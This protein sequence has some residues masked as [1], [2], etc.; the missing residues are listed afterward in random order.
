M[1]VDTCEYEDY[2]FSKVCRYLYYP[3]KGYCAFESCI[4]M[5]GICNTTK[6]ISYSSTCDGHT[7]KFINHNFVKSFYNDINKA[8]KYLN[9][10]VKSKIL[11]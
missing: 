7:R 1:S 3:T 9:L 6:I 4:F 10:L 8:Q 5:A 2:T 11:I